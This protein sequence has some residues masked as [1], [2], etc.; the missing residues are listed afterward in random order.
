MQI[1]QM[2]LS[3]GAVVALLSA[4]GVA[5]WAAADTPIVILDGSLKMQSKVPW[6]Q[7]KGAG[8]TKS[9]PNAGGSITS[10][11][12]TLNGK[13]QTIDCNKVRCTVDVTY[14]GTDVQVAGAGA[15][16]KGLTVSPFSAFQNGSSANELV[17]KN[18]NAHIAQLTVSRAGVK[19]VNTA[20]PGAG[21]QVTVH[22]Q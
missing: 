16:G 18:Q 21:T 6:N 2:R 17:H 19:V 15:N 22:Y 7:F 20:N 1:K 8:D 5:G 10:V 12:V 13:D 4:A 11:V 14:A 9:H 3:A